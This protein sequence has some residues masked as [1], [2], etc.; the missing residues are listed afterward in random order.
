MNRQPLISVI[1]PVY[2]V[3]KYVGKCVDSIL[4]QSYKNLDIILVDDG[5]TDRSG[6]ICDDYAHHN[7]NIRVIHQSNGGLSAARNAGLDVMTG[8][9]VTFVDSDD[10]IHR[11]CITTLYRYIE[12]ERAE[13]STISA[14]DIEDDDVCPTTAPRGELKVFYS[15]VEAVESMLFQ[16][17]FIDNS[18]WGKLYKA[19]FFETHRFPVGILYE[20]LATIPYVC[21]EAKCIATSATPL[22]FYRKRETSIL[23]SFS[24]KRSDVLDVVDDLVKFMGQHHKE[25][26]DAACS[27]KFS[28]NMNILWLM[29]ATGIKDDAIVARCWENIKQ[30]RKMTLI[31]PRVR[32]K[33]KLGA[34]TSIFGFDFL[35]IVLKRFKD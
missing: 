26:I 33:N 25:L 1:V 24:L 19:S 15:G 23:G 4:N 35:M 10:M 11:E 29:S 31:N 3:E 6:E 13:I 9:Y 2:N 22:Y 14:I 8:E 5:S 17:R 30:L 34:L 21:L 20:D 27:R 7:A 32:M 16:Q 18:A 12:T 28:A